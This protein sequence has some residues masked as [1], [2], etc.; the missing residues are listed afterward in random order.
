[1]GEWHKAGENYTVGFQQAYFYFFTYF[2][3]C[4]VRGITPVDHVTSAY[5]IASGSHNYEVFNLLGD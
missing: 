4:L 2:F 1:M 5:V 3:T